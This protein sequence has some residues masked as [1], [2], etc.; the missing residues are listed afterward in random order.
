MLREGQKLMICE[1][2][3][4]AKGKKGL[5]NK[6]NDLNISEE[7]TI[8]YLESLMNDPSEPYGHGLVL[9]YCLLNDYSL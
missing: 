7:L 5:F 4:P 3:V 8:D 6:C 1:I 2:D 9:A